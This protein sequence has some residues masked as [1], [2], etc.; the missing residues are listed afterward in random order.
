MLYSAI[1]KICVSKCDPGEIRTHDSYIKSVV[2]FQLSYEIRFYD[3]KD[4]T[5]ANF[6]NTPFQTLY[7]MDTSLYLLELAFFQVLS[8]YS[9]CRS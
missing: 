1:L 9:Q 2:L 8:P 3:Y 6:R 7:L 5:A 4:F